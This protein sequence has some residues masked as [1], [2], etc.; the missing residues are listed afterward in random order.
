MVKHNMDSTSKNFLGADLLATLDD[1]GKQLHVTSC[2][3][4]WREYSLEA[5]SQ[6]FSNF[7]NIFSIFSFWKY[8]WEKG[9]NSFF[10]T[11]WMN[12]I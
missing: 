11:I 9:E 7:P 4:E 1:K 8:F 5:I 2:I 6:D 3:A 10:I 12:W